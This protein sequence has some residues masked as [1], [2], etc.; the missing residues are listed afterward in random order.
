VHSIKEKKMSKEFKFWM[1]VFAFLFVGSWLYTQ[2]RYETCL[3]DTIAAAG[4]ENTTGAQMF[5][6]SLWRW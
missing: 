4:K 2:I 1:A 5:C 3:S 6:G